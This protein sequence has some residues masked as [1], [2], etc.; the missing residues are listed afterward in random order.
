MNK[1]YLAMSSRI[2]AEFDELDQVV[3]RV[4]SAWRRAASTGD[5]AY[6]DSVALNLHGLY[7][8]LERIFTLIASSIDQAKPAGENWH[9]DLL[10]T[11]SVEITGVRPAVL[12]RVTME[13]LDPYRGFRQVVRNVY[14]FFLSPG[15]MAPL[16][17]DLPDVYA[18]AKA[19]ILRFT[20]ALE[21]RGLDQS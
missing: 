5:N 3:A 12:S 20:S 9:H 2:K 15:R 13:K 4:L 10:R 17:T 18:Q 7:S 19:D 16:V 14:S 11:M 8:G 21:Q 6:I 1:R